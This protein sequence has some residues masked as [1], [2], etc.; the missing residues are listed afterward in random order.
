APSDLAGHLGVVRSPRRLQ[1]LRPLH[2]QHAAGRQSAVAVHGVH[3]GHDGQVPQ[4]GGP[5]TEPGLMATLTKYVSRLFFSHLVVVLI[6]LVA[7]VQLLDLLSNAEHIM[8][9]H[10]DS[11]HAL[12]HYSSLRLPELITLLIPF[13]VLMAS[14]L[15]I[16][17]LARYNEVMALKAAGMSFYKLLAAFAPAALLVALTHLF[18]SDQVTPHAT[19]ALV[20]WDSSA[21]EVDQSQSDETSSNPVWIRNGHV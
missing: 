13:S 20:E 5:S 11:V 9:R 4:P 12:L 7:L 17:R 21:L 14:L 3:P 19:R 8:K 15:W 1:Q 10:G 16:A 18:L 6:G 2:R